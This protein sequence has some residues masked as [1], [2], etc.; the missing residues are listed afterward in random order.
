MIKI[1]TQQLLKDV[2]SLIETDNS[3]VV[4]AL[5]EIPTDKVVLDQETKENL[6]KD[7]FIGFEK[8]MDIII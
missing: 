5:C 4:N 7:D 6:R 3:I 1:R 8:D 2:K